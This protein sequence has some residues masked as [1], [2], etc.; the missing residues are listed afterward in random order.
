HSRGPDTALGVPPPRLVQ[1]ARLL[2]RWLSAWND[3][4][5][6]LGD[7]ATSPICGFV[8]HNRLDRSLLIYGTR[9]DEEA[10]YGAANGARPPIGKLL[11]AVQEVEYIGGGGARPAGRRPPAAPLTPGP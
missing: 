4:Q 3:N 7:L 2:P 10:I 1:P 5:E 6:S 11:G 8:V 9:N